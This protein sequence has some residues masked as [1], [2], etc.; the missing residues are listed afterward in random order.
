MRL[1]P[2]QFAKLQGKATGAAKDETISHGERLNKNGPMRADNTAS[3]LTTTPPIA[4][5][6]SHG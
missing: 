1:T 5:G 4:R 3:T 2:A 6:A